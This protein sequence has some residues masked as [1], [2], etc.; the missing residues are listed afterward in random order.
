MAKA[1]LTLEL[2]KYSPAKYVPSVAA[3]ILFVAAKNDSHCSFEA[4]E[5]A[6]EAA[7]DATL[8]AR[9]CTHFELYRG[10]EFAAVVGAEVAFFVEHAKP[11]PPEAAGGGEEAEA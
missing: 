2:S 5:A 9:D 10:K 3:P 11:T 4:V 7:R 8:L 6:V 1:S